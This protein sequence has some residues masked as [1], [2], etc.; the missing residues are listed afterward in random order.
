M[1]S[2][3][4][5][6]GIEI[7]DRDLILAAVS[8]GLQGY[9]LKGDRV[10]ENYA[11][12]PVS[13]LSSRIHEFLE[14]HG[15]DRDNVVLGLPRHEVIIKEVEMPLEAEEN[16]DQVLQFQVE[17]MQPVDEVTS[18]WDY[19]VVERDAESKKLRIQLFM[20]PGAVLD[21]YLNLFLEV[22]LY[23]RA[24]R[25][26][27]IG[28]LQ[29]FS[30]HEDPYP[31]AAPYLL[32]DIGSE[33]LELI[34]LLGRE[35]FASVKSS[36]AP[37]V[38]RILEELDRFVARMDFEGEELAKVY[39]SGALAGELSQQ[40]RER[41]GDC[42]LLLERVSLPGL[43]STR[44]QAAVCA[45]AVG[46]ALSGMNKAVG[47][48][49]N[50]I[51]REKRVVAERVSLTPT[52]ALAALLLVMGVAVIAREYIQERHFLAQVENQIQILQPEVDRIMAVR[53]QRDQL[54]KQF[55]EISVLMNGQQ[56]VLTV[57]KELT[58]RIPNDSFL[59]NINIQGDKI[60]MTGFSDSASSLLKLLTELE[61]LERVES[62]YITPDRTSQN[63]ERFSFEATIKE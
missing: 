38:E 32:M 52:L 43:S 42:E 21:R 39:L 51:P 44:R 30:I 37:D 15:L 17:K 8:R 53:S 40:L 41:I 2:L 13:E 48:K 49:V 6:F 25:V 27:T 61:H 26:S 31:K 28:L 3:D 36:T 20:A 24:V 34:L 5:A 59:Q 9:Q 54:R 29:I 11:E 57:L 22:N 50:L 1:L 46:L 47:A 10:V 14:M 58:E 23:P 7:R 33:G 55:D 45:G 62:R 18:C 12:M 56:K 4:S 63:R 60:S 35:R 16:L 19:T